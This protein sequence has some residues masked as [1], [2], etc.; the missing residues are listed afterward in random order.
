MFTTYVLYS[1]TADRLYIG[2]T[3]DIDARLQRHNAG[4]VRS[5]KAYRPW[6]I[7]YTESFPTRADAMARERDLK[8]HQGRA[9]IRR[10][11]LNEQPE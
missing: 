11:I 9:F 5:T 2:H 7:I 3:S 1:A 8:S 10:V 6:R 4:K